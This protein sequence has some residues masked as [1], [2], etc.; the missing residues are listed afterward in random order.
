MA[1]LAPY[2]I[3]DSVEMNKDEVYLL[4]LFSAFAVTVIATVFAVKRAKPT[5]RASWFVACSLVTVFLLGII[6][7]ISIVVS[8]VLLALIKKDDDHPLSDIL[9]SFL[10]VIGSG[11][12]IA[13]YGCFMLLGVGG[14]YWL[15]LAVQ[16]KSFGMFVIGMFPLAYIVTA[17]VGAYSLVFGTPVW[18]YNVFG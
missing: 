16:L 11:A 7:P 15:W 14:L 9:S 10:V 4:L 5:H 12:S 18:V 2:Y 13:I 6:S 17:P 8:L 3:G 1:A